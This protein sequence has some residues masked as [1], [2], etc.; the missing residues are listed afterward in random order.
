MADVLAGYATEEGFMSDEHYMGRTI[1]P[2]ANRVMTAQGIVNHSGV[3]SFHNKEFQCIEQTANTVKLGLDYVDKY[4][5]YPP[6]R[7]E[8]TYTLSSDGCVTIHHKV[9]PS[10]PTYL[11]LTNHAYFNLRGEGTAIGQTF[12][13]EADQYLE[14]NNEFMPTG[15]ILPIEHNTL[16]LL[17]PELINNCYLLHHR[18]DYDA[19]LIDPLSGR[20]LTIKTSLPAVLFYSG[21]FLSS[22]HSGKQQSPLQPCEGVAIET[23]FCPDSQHNPAFP[24]C[25]FTCKHIYSHTTQYQFTTL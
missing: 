20:V 19:R 23:Q 15:R 17:K 4:G 12:E 3:S 5:F 18:G 9:I 11:S 10:Q 8:V 21:S 24:R 7:V 1:G 2:F 6:M 25:V 13:V 14:M 22:T 16:S